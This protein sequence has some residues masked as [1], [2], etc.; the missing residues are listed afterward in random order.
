MF[1]LLDLMRA[2]AGRWCDRVI[3][4]CWTVSDGGLLLHQTRGTDPAVINDGAA[5]LRAEK[6]P[7]EQIHL[8]PHIS[9][10]HLLIQLRV[11]INTYFAGL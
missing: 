2:L 10:L 3:Q 8:P 11:A 4:T 7:S 1:C 6:R 5:F 9:L